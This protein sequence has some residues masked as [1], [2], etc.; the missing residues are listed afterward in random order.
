MKDDDPKVIH[1]SISTNNEEITEKKIE[2]TD[3]VEHFTHTMRFLYIDY[4]SEEEEEEEELDAETVRF[5]YQFE[6]ELRTIIL[7][8][9]DPI[10]IKFILKFFLE[11]LFDP[12]NSPKGKW[13]ELICDDDMKI[14]ALKVINAVLYS[15]I[16]QITTEPPSNKTSE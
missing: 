14:N 1:L 4:M 6:R 3:W 10:V 16:K 2:I 13:M 7:L 5:S 12:E 8:D 9:C 15:T 11:N